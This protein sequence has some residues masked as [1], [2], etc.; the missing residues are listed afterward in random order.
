MAR[1]ITEFRVEK[2]RGVRLAFCDAVPRLMVVAG[3]NGCGKS[4]LLDSIRK[5][6]HPKPIYVGPHRVSRR[7]TVQFRYMY[8]AN[9][10]SIEK[11]FSLETLQ[12]VEGIT[13]ST[14]PRSAWDQDESTSFVKYGLCKVEVERAEALRE[15]YDT[16]G[17]IKKGLPDVWKPFR[18]LLA[19]LVPHLEFK[20]IDTNIK[21]NIR[22]LF[23]ANGLET[24][25]DLD[26]LSSGEKSVVQLFYPLIEHQIK[27]E[28]ERFRLGTSDAD[29]DT[30]DR[31]PWCILIDEPELHLHP[32][33]QIKV[34]DY[35]RKLSESQ[36]SQVILATQSTAIVEHA[37]FE[38]LYLL[39]P[40]GLIEKEVNQLK[41][42]AS[43]EERMKTIR[44]LFGSA[45]NLTAMQPIVVVEGVGRDGDTKVVSDKQLY[46]HLDSRFDQVTV[47]PGGG[48]GQAIELRK[49][50][51]AMLAEFSDEIPVLA[52]VDGDT[53]SALSE[54]DCHSLPVSMI[55]NFL[56]DPKV[57]WSAMESIRDKTELKTL[58]AVEGAIDRILDERFEKEIER[59]VIQRMGYRK[60]QPH[61]PITEFAS[62][63]EEFCK[64]LRGDFNETQV[65]QWKQDAEQ[66]V[67][68]IQEKVRRR[69]E[70]SGKKVL[71]SLF[72]QCLHST[73][74]S[75]EIFLYYAAREAGK[76]TSVKR[77]FDE[78]FSGLFPED[79]E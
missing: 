57:I 41:Q 45:V 39:R 46:R 31:D 58:E 49:R 6:T 11:L 4:T 38:E 79:T 59:R 71:S 9:D 26:D 12:A 51:H 73:G 52:L 77:F 37:T 48:K 74:L 27:A 60:F 69:E 25:I 40:A 67:R 7:Q 32:A 14:A 8:P 44:E 78:F 72:S 13:I 5:Q 68:T 2:S 20:G 43:D 24:P 28:L 1:R 64:K 18:E 70:Y 50:I 62:Q 47:V 55:E 30:R 23:E 53:G 56:V 76:R 16:H 10:I 75:M 35:L 34:F 17:E 65:T 33:L 21:T 61:R 29:N 3:P 42:V 15:C 66:A 22:C 54:T 36:D 63:I 19:F